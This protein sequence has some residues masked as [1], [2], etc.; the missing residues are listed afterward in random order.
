MLNQLFNSSAGFAWGVRASAFVTLGLL[1]ISN[2]VMKPRPNPPAGGVGR[3]P[4]DMK[5]HLIKGLK[6][7]PF[8]M[9]VLA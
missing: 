1:I 8:M 7:F 3:P 9:A 5:A 6:D 2:L 4:P